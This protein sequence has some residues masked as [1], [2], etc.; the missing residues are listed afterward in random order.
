MR[1][2]YES[3]AATVL[4]DLAKSRGIKGTSAMKKAELVEIM[5]ATD[6]KEKQ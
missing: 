2:K 5:L 4:R 1:A 3:L 6:E